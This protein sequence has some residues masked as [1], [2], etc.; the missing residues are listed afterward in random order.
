[1]AAPVSRVVNLWETEAVCEQPVLL[2]NGPRPGK[3]EAARCV[4]ALGKSDLQL[5]PLAHSKRCQLVLAKRVA[6]CRHR[7]PA[8]AVASSDH[9]KPEAP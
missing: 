5:D 2:A 1:M 6:E 7:A 4:A 8:C 9:G 3:A